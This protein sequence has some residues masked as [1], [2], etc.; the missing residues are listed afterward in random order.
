M[1]SKTQVGLLA[2][3]SGFVGVTGFAL[4][5]YW[6][7][8]RKQSEA[9]VAALMESKDDSEGEV[10]KNIVE[11]KTKEDEHVESMMRE[12]VLVEP[13]SDSSSGDVN[14][15]GSSSQGS[16]SGSGSHSPELQSS[17]I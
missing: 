11:P 2:L 3:G 5:N 6:N 1:P 12:D 8:R 9:R 17:V 16:P 13:S 7:R 14:E 4:W 15:K 10:A